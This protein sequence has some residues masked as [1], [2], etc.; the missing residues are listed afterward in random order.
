MEEKY[1]EMKAMLY[2]LE[3]SLV[4]PPIRGGYALC[5]RVQTP[6]SQ[7]QWQKKLSRR[8]DETQASDHSPHIHVSGI[9]GISAKASPFFL[10][11]TVLPSS[12]PI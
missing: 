6:E 11:W 1:E 5:R 4:E 3:D 10:L 12:S 2:E 8:S 9:Y 7:R